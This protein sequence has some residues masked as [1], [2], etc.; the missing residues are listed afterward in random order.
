[1]FASTVTKMCL[2]ITN[3]PYFQWSPQC[4][5]DVWTNYSLVTS[6]MYPALGPP[7]TLNGT[8]RLHSEYAPR[9][10][11]DVFDD[12]I[13]NVSQISGVTNFLGYILNVAAL[14]NVF[15]TC[16][17]CAQSIHLGTL[18]SRDWVHSKGAQ[19]L[20]RNYIKF[21]FVGMFWM[22]PIFYHW[23]HCDTGGKGSITQWVHGEYIVGSETICPPF[24]HWVRGGYFPK[25]PNKVP[26][27]C[28]SHS[29]WV[30]LK[31]TMFL[32]DY[33]EINTVGTFESELF[34]NPLCTWCGP[35]G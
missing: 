33:I 12:H 9:S 16:Q 2:L 20:P 17:K 21:T 35:T 29:L 1:M 7:C 3:W 27:V 19:C 31:S 23:A 13:Q 6:W 5:H 28:L 8:C 25:V 14:L 4:Y 32:F 34:L 24:T 30:L 11:P 18:R 26:T 10:N 22:Y 15:N